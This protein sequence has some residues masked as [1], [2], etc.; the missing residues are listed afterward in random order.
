MPA[1][2]TSG[3]LVVL[4]GADV[5]A[6]VLDD[7]ED[8]TRLSRAICTLVK[9]DGGL[10]VATAILS[11]RVITRAGSGD[12]RLTCPNDAR[13]AARP[14]ARRRSRASPAPARRR[15]RSRRRPSQTR[16][17]SGC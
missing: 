11:W 16:G 3:V 12:A 8:V 17:C 1:R 6:L 14:Q 7:R 15:R 13:A 4:G 10:P 5:V 9:P 2:R